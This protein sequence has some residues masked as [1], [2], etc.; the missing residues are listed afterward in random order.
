MDPLNRH[1][2]ARERGTAGMLERLEA[3]AIYGRNIRE[4]ALCLLEAHGPAA[5]GEALNAAREPGIAE[6]ERQF[7]EAVAARVA[8][9]L[10]H[11]SVASAA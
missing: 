1:S 4:R 9:Q 11:R 6:T 2:G 8:R 5:W 3:R 10:G 7:W